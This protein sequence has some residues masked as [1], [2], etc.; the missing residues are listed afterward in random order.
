MINSIKKVIDKITDVIWINR[1]LIIMLL[2]SI[3]FIGILDNVLDEDI[4]NFD[5]AGYEFVTTK[6]SDTVTWFAKIITK[7]A[8]PVILGLIAFSIF[9]AVK[10]KKIKY[11]V[12]VNLIVAALLN[13]I[14]IWLRGQGGGREE[15]SQIQ[16]AAAVRAQE[17]REELLHVQIWEGRTCP[18]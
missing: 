2:F 13:F 11:S 8:S 7:M 1:R 14:I 5:I 16:G 4:Y 3:L 10:N 6:M 15:L 12:I 9:F 18:R 17:G